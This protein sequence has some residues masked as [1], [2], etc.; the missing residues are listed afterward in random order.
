MM[1][2]LGPQ[3]CKVIRGL[4]DPKVRMELMGPS[5]LLVAK[6]LLEA[7]AFKE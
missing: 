5:D 1:A 4:R 6:D 7:L 3:E 2:L